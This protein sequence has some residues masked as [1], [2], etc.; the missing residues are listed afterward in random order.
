MAIFGLREDSFSVRLMK[1]LEK[2]S[3]RFADAAITTNEAF[4]KIFSSRGCPPEKISVIMNS[5]DEEIFQFREQSLPAL[6]AP[7]TAKPFVIMYHGS[8]VERHGLDLAVTALAKIR[9]S[10]PNAELR[11]FGK[12]TPFLGQVMDFVRRTDLSEAVRYLGPKTLEQ[13]AV[14][15]SECDVG[16]IPNRQSVFTELNMPTR[17]FEFLSQGKPVIAPRSAG[18]LDYFGPNELI[19]FK[20]GDADDLAVK[21]QCVFNHPDEVAKIVQRGQ[22]VYRAHEWSGQRRRFMSLVSELLNVMLV[23]VLLMSAGLRVR[24]SAAGRNM[25]L[26][27]HHHHLSVR[28]IRLVGRRETQLE[29]QL[30]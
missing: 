6:A 15:I 7:H 29:E 19:L 21:L 12:S 17:I 13:I 8:L 3:V 25:P 4:K 16:I 22:N 5:P 2:W 30:I 10:I 26:G 23:C 18:I 11:I 1:R 14:A 24:S 28:N 9:G 27:F 20:L